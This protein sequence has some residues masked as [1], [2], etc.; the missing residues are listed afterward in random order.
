MISNER[1]QQTMSFRRFLQGGG[2]ERNYII[3][4][5][6]SYA[7]EFAGKRGG[8]PT[9]ED[10]FAF[11][12]KFPSDS[13][14]CLEFAL[15]RYVPELVWKRTVLKEEKDETCVE[16]T[17]QL[18]GDTKRR[19]VAEKRGTIPWLVESS[20][21]TEADFDLIDYYSEK[22]QEHA[23]TIAATVTPQIKQCVTEGFM[24][25][26]VVLTPFEAYWLIDYPDMPVMYYDF[27]D[28]YL[29]TIEKVHQSNLVLIKELAKAG[30]EMFGM[31][32]AGLE[33][34]S[35]R[36][37]DEAIIPY[38]RETTDYIRS[39]GAFS[40]YHICGHSRQLLE[41]GRINA[42]KPTWFETFSTPP[43][44][45]NNSLKES[46]QFLDTDIISKGN[47]PLDLL[48]KGPPAEIRRVTRDIINQSN[49]RRHIIGQADGTIL[50]G[51]P[52]ENIQAFLS[53]ARDYG[54]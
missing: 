12:A 28:R 52:H 38:A 50:S 30:C 2:K 24:P 43:C 11:H 44:G 48:L 22:I 47:L 9:L 15:E 49:K 54:N 3:L 17:I 36:I 33:L 23:R 42:I 46:L 41:T 1:G 34:L 8:H 26:A 6:S 27:P 20:I 35:P 7:A 21:R 31:G 14:L 10:T 29:L 51:T 32:S 40:C 53:V 39:L 16:E 5:P 13:P 25:A 4:D 18:H 37:F 45:N 19:V